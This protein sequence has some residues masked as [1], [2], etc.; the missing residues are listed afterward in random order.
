MSYSLPTRASAL[1]IILGTAAMMVPAA[2]AKS[3]AHS[4]EDVTVSLDQASMTYTVDWPDSFGP[5]I[6]AE[7][8][9]SPDTPVGKGTVIA[10]NLSGSAFSWTADTLDERKYFTLVPASGNPVRVA[11][12][13]LPLEGGRNFRDIGGYETEDGQTV[14]WGRVFRSGVMDDLTDKDYSYLSGLGIKVV[15]DLRTARERSDEPTDWQAG[16]AQYLTFPDPAE[17]DAMGLMAIFQNPDATPQMVSQVM[18]DSYADI[19]HDQAPA[20]REMFDRLAGGDIPL[21]FNCSAGKD[22]TGIGAAL[23]LTALGVPR[24][25]VVADYALSETYVDYMKEFAGASEEAI[26]ED[27]PYAFLAKLPPEMVMPLM[28]SDPLYIETALADIE[29]EYGSVMAFLQEEIDVTDEELASIRAQ[30]LD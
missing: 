28:R 27:S 17:D 25:T 9:S 18:A 5:G 14:K 26:P 12:R 3:P 29:E 16:S 2:C 4:A 24:E 11:L 1:A 22:R 15:C 21:A 20:Y 10:E 6:V 19:A 7:V 23:I 13:L 30:L 8:S